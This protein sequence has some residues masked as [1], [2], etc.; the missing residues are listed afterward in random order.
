MFKKFPLRTT[1]VVPFL[2][3]MIAVVGLIWWITY[4]SGQQAVREVS[5]QLR[6]E[7]TNRINEK[8]DSYT[9]IPKRIDRLNASAFAYEDIDVS[10]PRGQYRFWQQMQIYQALSYIYCSDEDGGF[11]GVGRLSNSDR[12]QLSL[13]FS[14]Q[15]TN[16]LRQDFAFDERG[17][18]AD[19]IGTL[20]E[21]FDPRVRPWYRAAKVAGKGV[22]SEIYLSFSTQH[23]T[24]T[25]SFPVYSRDDNSLIGVCAAD[26]FLPEEVSLFLQKLQIGKTGTAFIMERSG[27][28]VATSSTAAMVTKTD[29]ERERILASNS[30]DETIRTTANYL[31]DRFSNFQNIAATRQ[32][33]FSL[34]GEKQYVQIAPFQD[35]NLDWLIVLT[36]PEADFMAQIH[37][38]RRNAVWL[39]V[40]ALGIAIS[41]GVLTSR[42]VT[43]PILRVSGAS[44]EL[45]K[46]NLNQRVAPSPIIEI[47]TLANSFNLMARQLQD[48]FTTLEQKNEKLRITEENYRSIFE[49]ALEGIF[50]SSPEGY[51]LSVNPAL[52]KIYGYDSPQEMIDSVKNIGKQLYV[53]S[54]KRAKFRELLA[55]DGKVK[56]F[57]YR[58][59]CK[60]GSIIWTEIDARVVKDDRGNPLY[61]EG[62]VQDISD[63]K[64]REANLRKQLKELKVEIDQK[65]RA[66]EVAKLT[67]S[68]YF[69][70]VQQEIAEV[71]L[72]EFWS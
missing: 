65:K 63:R 12:S 49:N 10:N 44:D 1:L 51:Y 71:D 31:S 27:R 14:N 33:E 72:D 41:I 66:E 26:F 30:E 69:Q 40:G 32:L 4:R 46:G 48:S 61:Y 70:E 25:Y 52:A 6:D 53:D 62:I 60:D 18:P 3:Q 68:N 17:N 54:E 5:S 15:S 29:A 39:S 2:L 64:Q 42:W 19:K 56:N 57:E 47:D 45:A 37:A 36:V 50:Q 8:L 28:L 55:K 59:Y 7:I 58:C 9:D 13:L 21:P 34:N 16:F 43:R 23:P 11:L 35:D 22:W 20:N 38:S 67:K 24:V